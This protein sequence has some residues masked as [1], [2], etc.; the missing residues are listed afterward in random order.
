M[1]TIEFNFSSSLCTL[2]TCLIIQTP[3]DD[4]LVCGDP[5]SY[6]S[7]VSWAERQSRLM[8]L[9]DV[10]LPLGST[11]ADLHFQATHSHWS[12]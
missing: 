1:S 5:V 6:Q 12:G 9:N 8:E 11:T 10:L 7:L 3:A 2:S 4:Q